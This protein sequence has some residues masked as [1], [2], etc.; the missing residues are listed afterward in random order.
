MK[1]SK[2]KTEPV[3]IGG[4]II[5]LAT[6]IGPALVAFGVDLT[7]EQLAAAQ[8]VVVAVVALVSL[9]VRGQVTPTVRVA[10]QAQR[11][12]EEKRRGK[13]DPGGGASGPDPRPI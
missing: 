10:M 1:H 11:E 6:A 8:G 9:V 2:A 7:A 3:T 13:H 5:A 12:H 4:A